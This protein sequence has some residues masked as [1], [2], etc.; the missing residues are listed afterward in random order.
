M[1]RCLTCD[2]RY[3]DERLLCTADSDMLIDEGRPALESGR[4][5]SAR[6][7]LGNLL[8]EGGMGRV[9]EATRL[10]DGAVVAVKILKNDTAS[11]PSHDEAVKRLQVEAEAGASLEHPGVT[12]V[13]E[14]C[15]ESDGASF[16]VMERL[17][18]S[19]LD[20]L[21]RAGR[22][23]ST[24][25]VLGLLTEVCDVLAAAH[26]C[27]IVHRDLKPS[28][29]FVH[30]P[31]RDRFQVKVLDF[32][33]AKML[34]RQ[35]TKLTSTGE[36]LG[37]LLYMA[38]ELTAGHPVTTAAD[39]YSLG[40]IL[41]EALA[42]KTPFAGRSPMEIIRVHAS[43][44][45]PSLSTF[46]PDLPEE[47]EA[48]VARC[49]FKKP[50]GRFADAAALAQALRGVPHVRSNAAGSGEPTLSLNPSQWVGI[51]LDETYEIHEWIAP[52]R[53]GSD[54]YR[55]THLRTGAI[56]AVRLWRTGRGSVRDHLFEAFRR[57]ARAMGV[58]HTNLIAILDLG[59]N[60]ECVYIVTELLES[61]SL[62]TLM[63][64]RNELPRPVVRELIRGAAEALAALHARDI[65]S[66]GLSPETVRVVVGASGP[67]KLVLTPFGLTSLNQ[68]SALFPRREVAG[69]RDRSRDYISPEQIAGAV[70][71]VRSD[72]YSLGLI[73]LE[74][75]GGEVPELPRPLARTSSD[76]E[77]SAE[78][79]AP[80]RE[81]VMPSDLAA[82]WS[83]FLR[84]AVARDP[85]D[86]FQTAQE[87][88][89]ALP[90]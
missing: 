33:I 55:A 27:G 14:H 11:G 22:F 16:I 3:E 17:Y 7:Q 71:D 76:F 54:V 78:D 10:S 70:P 31:D 80:S 6:Y 58:R 88:L 18:G 13:Y 63:V 45:A 26:S 42:G 60:D 30:R 66:G 50:E 73:L 87:M 38:P 41:F 23:A 37:T 25:R 85:A 53:F 67:E 49:L 84:K 82:E 5:L 56:V 77:L 75:V 69:E 19:T 52:G 83:P 48:L 86:R 59:Y 79:A 24:E 81:V 4:T 68:L 89:S 61:I 34:Y 36:F 47:L 40:V 65:V 32:G 15:Q 74:M 29:I 72:L 12:R 8:G 64:R 28:N 9:F 39:V 2:T 46:R 1:R 57:E 21:R 44:P 90:R 43:A 62:R 35:G 51:V 20:E